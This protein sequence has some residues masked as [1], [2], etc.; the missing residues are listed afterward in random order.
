MKLIQLLKDIRGESM[1]NEKGYTLLIVLITITIIL[2][3]GMSLSG[4]VLSSRY[5]FNKTDNRNKATDLA[6]MGI[7]YYKAVTNRI[8]A[9]ANT[10]AS[11]NS[12]ST[13]YDSNFKSALKAYTEMKTGYIK[14]MTVES[15]KTYKIN[16]MNIDESNPNKLVVNFNSFGNAG[17]ETV[18]L[19]GS[20]TIQKLSG[21][22]RI[23][24]TKP[25]QSSYS[26][27]ETNLIDLWA[28]NKSATYNSS[29]YF[30]NYIHIQGN[31]TLLV[32]GDAYFVS[33]V[34]YQGAA[35]II[36][37]GDAIFEK[38]MIIPNGKA[39]KLCITGDTY[40]VDSQGKLI[41]YVIPQNRCAKT[42]SN[43]WG[44]DNNSGIKVQ[45]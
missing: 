18:N 13:T 22:L 17:K 8:V 27:V 11:L 35:D 14:L 29:T 28:Q 15:D 5:Q 4:M 24:Q 34:S 43:S 33:E 40:L 31:R 37:K 16:F 12:T 32:N 45:Y 7:T 44:I 19:T 42:A 26:I 39:Y 36:I 1:K 6:E 9:A 30:T 21:K 10:T 23:G 41:D 38:A 2:I 3:F 25:V 20:I